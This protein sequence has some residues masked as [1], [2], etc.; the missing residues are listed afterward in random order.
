MLCLTKCYLKYFSEKEYSTLSTPHPFHYA[1]PTPN[2]Q[3]KQD[4]V[5][6]WDPL[7]KGRGDKVSTFK[8]AEREEAQVFIGQTISFLNISSSILIVPTRVSL[9]WLPLNCFVSPF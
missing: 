3:A 8:T 1:F 4:K 2:N 5:S 6:T 9:I 7:L